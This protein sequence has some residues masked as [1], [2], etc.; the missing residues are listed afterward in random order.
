MNEVETLRSH[1]I[2]KMDAK[3][4]TL[5]EAGYCC[6]ECQAFAPLMSNIDFSAVTE[7]LF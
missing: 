5:I 1:V 3:I 2:H 7:V 6:H 4:T